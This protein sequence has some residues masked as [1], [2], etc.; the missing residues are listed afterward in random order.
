MKKRVSHNIFFEALV[1][2]V[3]STGLWAQKKLFQ[4]SKLKIN[5]L[6]LKLDLLKNHFDLNKEEISRLEKEILIIR[7]MD[8]KNKLRDLK[9]FECL[10]AEKAMPHFLNIAK[11]TKAADT[12]ANI[13]KDDGTE[14]NSTKEREIHI[15]NFYSN[16]YKKDQNVVPN[17]EEFLGAEICSHPLVTSSKLSEE[18]RGELDAPINIGEID[19]ALQQVNIK[20]APGVDGYSYRF[21]K[22]YWNVFRVPLFE[23]ARE[24][25]ESGTMPV[26]F[27]TAQIKLIPKKGNTNNAE[28]VHSG[29]AATRSHN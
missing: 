10:N 4:I 29:Q 20:S 21:I 8:L 7:D 28:R 26:F 2:E 6:E 17:I 9:I 3:R 13:K 12:L 11:Q 14:F 18:E 1:R 16:L 5:T 24:S 27:S 25:L 19:K 15:V 23:C 22:A